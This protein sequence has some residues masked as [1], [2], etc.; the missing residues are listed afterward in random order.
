MWWLGGLALAGAPATAQDGEI[1]RMA[2]FA[3][4]YGTLRW[5]HP[6]DELQV[7]DLD[8]LACAGVRRARAASDAESLRR[9]LSGLV[10]PVAPTVQLWTDDPMARL[11]PPSRAR[12]DGA[13]AWRHVGMGNPWWSG[14]YAS[15]RTGHSPQVARSGDRTGWV[16]WRRPAGELAGHDVRVTATARREPRSVGGVGLWARGVD[17]AGQTV[18]SATTAGNMVAHRDWVQRALELAVPDDA[19]TLRFGVF[20]HGTGVGWVDDVTLEVRDAAGWRSVPVDGGFERRRGAWETSGDGYAFRVS[21]TDGAPQGARAMRIERRSRPFEPGFT[22]APPPPGSE[23]LEDLGAGVHVRVPLTVPVLRS[24]ATWPAGAPDALEAE[25]RSNPCHDPDDPDT[26]IAAVVMA[27]SVFQHFFPYFDDL[28]VDWDAALV[29]ALTEARDAESGADMIGVLER[30]L[31]P[32]AD[33]HGSVS[34][35]RYPL[36]HLPIELDLVDGQLVVVRPHGEDL[37]PGDVVVAVDRAPA[38]DV[39]AAERTRVS[40]SPQL[41]DWAAARRA[42]SGAE[43]ES[44]VLVVANGETSREVTLTSGFTSAPLQEGPAIEVLPDGVIYLDLNRASWDTIE[45]QLPALAA[46]PGVV[47]DLRRYPVNQA[48]RLLPHLLA[49]PCRHQWMWLPE[50]ARPNREGWTWRGVGW[51]VVPEAPHIGGPV[52]WITTSRA[53][54]FAESVMGFVPAHGLGPIVGEPTAGANGNVNPF[55]TPGG[56]QVSWTGMRVTTHAG[57]S[58]HGIGIAPSIPVTRT[59][60]DVREGRDPWREAALHEVRRLRNQRA[61][62]APPS[63]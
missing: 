10:H 31:V 35:P 63:Q 38:A 55:T 3:R 57:V 49:E 43:G 2:A 15:A 4:L 53:A 60:A 24:G 25:L 40:G 48:Y 20:L 21:R 14:P 29:S 7:V 39:V 33:G 9:S 27:W 47:V 62:A 45:A 8:A 23:V 56:F 61:G 30:L 34:H 13:T 52:V 37:V 1:E 22:H 6:S 58:L 46:A 17:E 42:G 16:Q 41:R 5:F 26:R 50:I 28:E 32:L 59:L 11:E 36:A 54:S 44:H 12:I 18:G 19:R 51:D